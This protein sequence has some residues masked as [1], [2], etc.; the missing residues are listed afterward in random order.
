ML[1]RVSGRCFLEGVGVADAVFSLSASRGVLESA[2]HWLRVSGKVVR[3]L[4]VC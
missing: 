2:E 4:T 3:S 1:A